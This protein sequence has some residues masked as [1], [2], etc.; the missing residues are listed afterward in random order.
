MKLCTSTQ[1]FSTL[2]KT[3]DL[4]CLLFYSLLVTLIN[5]R[6]VNKLWEYTPPISICVWILWE[7][8]S[9]IHRNRWLSPDQWNIFDTESC[10]RVSKEL[11]K[12]DCSDYIILLIGKCLSKEMTQV[13]PYLP[14]CLRLRVQLSGIIPS[15]F[16]LYHNFVIVSQ[17]FRSKRY[18]RHCCL[19]WI[20]PRRFDHHECFWY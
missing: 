14:Q 7:I 6:W 19:Y 16:L 10:R 15:N 8:Y 9:T 13:Y 1:E 18:C 11:S 4:A 5:L 12:A 17:H 2:R 3:I 20:Q